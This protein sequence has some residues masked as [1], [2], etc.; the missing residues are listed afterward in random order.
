MNK[1]VE[2]WSGWWRACGNLL[3]YSLCFYVLFEHSH[4]MKCFFPLFL[5]HCEYIVSTVNKSFTRTS[6]ELFQWSVPSAGPSRSIPHHLSVGGCYWS[7][8]DIWR[9][10]DPKKQATWPRT[11]DDEDGGR[12][13]TLWRCPPHTLSGDLPSIIVREH[14]CFTVRRPSKYYCAW[15]CLFH[16][17]APF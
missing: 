6:L 8:V 11:Q 5:N 2:H 16:C 3:Y 4:T 14:V 17:P 13:A 12:A 15:A 1:N 7:Q 9:T 10:W